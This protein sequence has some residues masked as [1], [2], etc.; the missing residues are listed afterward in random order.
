MLI[1]VRTDNHIRNNEA[2]RDEVRAELEG[3]L[4]RRFAE[5]LQRLE[6]YFQDTNS[7]KKGTD[8]RCAIEA[9]PAGYGP[10]A[11]DATAPSVEAAMDAAVE[12]L[13][14]ALAHRLGRLA[15]RNGRVSMSGQ[16][17]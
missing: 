11:V 7:H 13:E 8:I 10:V 16:E 9:H 6:V 14:R 15:D 17:T 5:R 3:A 2:L 4:T 12:M 1:Q